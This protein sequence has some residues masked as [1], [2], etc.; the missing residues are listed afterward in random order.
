VARLNRTRNGVEAPAGGDGVQ[1]AP[2]DPVAHVSDEDV[3]DEDDFDNVAW[4]A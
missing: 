1:D 3:P 4:E 2:S